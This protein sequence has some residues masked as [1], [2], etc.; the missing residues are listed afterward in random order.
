MAL[1]EIYERKEFKDLSLLFKRVSQIL[2]NVEVD[3]LPEISPTL[4]QERE[5]KDLYETLKKITPQLEELYTQKDYLTYLE[6]LL[7][8]K[9]LIDAFFDKV[10]VMVEEKELR[11]N[12]LSL[13]YSLSKLIYKIGDLSYLA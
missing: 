3:S 4:L 8:F 12:R 2:K 11:E 13:L 7:I 6:N 10:Y 1:K 5:E 9:P